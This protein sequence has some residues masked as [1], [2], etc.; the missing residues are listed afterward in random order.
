MEIKNLEKGLTDMVKG[1]PVAFKRLKKMEIILD[2]EPVKRVKKLYRKFD[3]NLSV[4]VLD[5]TAR[6]AKD[7][8]EILKL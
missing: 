4:L 2:K 1:M 3:S 7:A 8:A 5:N 6:T